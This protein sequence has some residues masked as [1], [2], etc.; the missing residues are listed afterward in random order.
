[1]VYGIMPTAAQSTKRHPRRKNAAEPRI[2]ALADEHV[3]ISTLEQSLW[4]A[5]YL[6]VEPGGMNR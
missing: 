2:A 5:A 3:D 1:M 6:T 4:N